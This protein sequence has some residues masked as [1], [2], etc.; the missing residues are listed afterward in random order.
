MSAGRSASVPADSWIW[1]SGW[2]ARFPGISEIPAVR[3]PL[4]T[5]GGKQI[6]ESGIEMIDFAV[7]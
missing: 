4:E 3:L 1:G 2:A 7:W 5:A 6:A